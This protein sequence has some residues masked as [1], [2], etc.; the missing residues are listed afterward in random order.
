MPSSASKRFLLFLA[1][2]SLKQITKFTKRLSRDQLKAVRELIFNLLKGRVPI[3]RE[4]LDSLT[5]HKRFLRELAY[6]GIQRCRMNKYCK[7][8]LKVLKLAKPFLESIDD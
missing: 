5:P 4:A 7:V 8:L 2:L 3:D 1:D 6:R